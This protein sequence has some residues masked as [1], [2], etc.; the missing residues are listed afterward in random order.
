M[1]KKWYLPQNYQVADS[2][3]E[4]GRMI[5][6]GVESFTELLET[7]FLG[8]SARIYHGNGLDETTGKDIKC[9]VQNLTSSS[10]TQDHIRQ[11]LAPI[12]TLKLG[13]Y[14]RFRN[15]IY[16]VTEYVDNNQVYEKANML[17]CNYEMKWRNRFG[18][19][20][21]RW[22]WRQD[23]TRFSSGESANVELVTGNVR[24]EILMPKD[25]ETIYLHRDQRLIMDD[26]DAAQIYDP[27]VYKITKEN[28]ILSVQGNNSM[29][30]FIIAE[31]SFD[32]STDNRELMIADYYKD[33]VIFSLDIISP[34]INIPNEIGLGETLQIQV[35]AK[36][37][38]VQVNDGIDYMSSNKHVLRVDEDGLVTALSEGNA[39]IVVEF[40][41]KRIN[42]A[43]NVVA[44]PI[45]SGNTC[46]ITYLGAPQIKIGGVAKTF[47]AEFYGADGNSIILDASWSIIDEHGNIPEYIT[48]V[49]QDSSQIVLKCEDNIHLVGKYFYLQLTDITILTNDVVRVDII[50]LT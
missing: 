5:E 18:N 34:S 41:D 4:D 35:D 1:G 48:I 30:S 32:P 39:S 38:G 15:T 7:T 29:F 25:H 11:I 17:H 40:H 16:L 3:F 19:I 50:S 31:D 23:S 24:N 36:I 13:T 37:D 22:I 46:S 33:A 47:N 2:G 43:V 26:Y 9:V 8:E 28:R 49:S 14:V 12:G 44:T 21:Y 27:L 6:Y 45:V 42:F 20:V 10:I